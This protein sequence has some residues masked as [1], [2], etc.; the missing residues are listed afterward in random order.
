LANVDSEVKFAPPGVLLKWLHFLLPPEVSETLDESTL[1]QINELDQATAK[2]IDETLM[3]LDESG[4]AIMQVLT[5][6]NSSTVTVETG[7]RLI[8]GQRKLR[9]HVATSSVE[10]LK[11]MGPEARAQLAKAEEMHHAPTLALGLETPVVFR[12][13]SLQYLIAETNITG[14]PIAASLVAEDMSLNVTL[15]QA[16]ERFTTALQALPIESADVGQNFL[17]VYG[18][19]SNALDDAQRTRF[20]IGLRL[21]ASLS[22]A[23]RARVIVQP[24]LTSYLGLTCGSKPWSG[25]MYNFADMQRNLHV[26]PAGL[27]ITPPEQPGLEHQPD[28]AAGYLGR[29]AADNANAPPAPPAPPPPSD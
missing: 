15:L 21:L 1:S 23:E 29:D 28:Y 5:S 13:Q 3:S 4:V 9:D 19:Y 27:P 25:A 8:D 20:D 12:P 10:A 26:D 24:P 7:Q 16:K 11:T 17:A 6:P 18:T 2:A 22:T 14:N